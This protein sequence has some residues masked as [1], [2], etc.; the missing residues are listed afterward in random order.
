MSPFQ[1]TM[2]ATGASVT[3]LGISAVLLL[4]PADAEEK[5]ASPSQPSLIVTP[6]TSMAFSGPRG[7]PFSPSRFE[8]RVSSTASVV[9][10]SIRTP[11]W[12]TASSTFGTTDTS[13]HHNHPHGERE[14]VNASAG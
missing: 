10:Y 7:G 14:R 2:M 9:R 8:Y 3:L 4:T 13:R 1:A 5:L 12:L 6:P 11:S